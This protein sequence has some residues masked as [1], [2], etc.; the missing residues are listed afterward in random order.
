MT[1]L[2][3][4]RYETHSEGAKQGF[5]GQMGLGPDPH[6]FS[7]E[8]FVPGSLSFL[9]AHG[10]ACFFRLVLIHMQICVSGLVGFFSPS[11]SFF[12]IITNI[13]RWWEINV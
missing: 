3:Y 1:N 6:L 8:L 5:W 4:F 13:I 11:S 2:L 9:S 10:D 7:Y 12:H